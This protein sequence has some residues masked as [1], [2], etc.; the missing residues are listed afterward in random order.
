[1]ARL[2]STF[3]R[4][5]GSGGLNIFSVRSI[6]NQDVLKVF[7]IEARLIGFLIGWSLGL[8]VEEKPRAHGGTRRRVS[9][10]CFPPKWGC[11]NTFL[12]SVG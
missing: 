11:V 3:R 10:W 4:E 5:E 1:M 12:L 9:K 6:N 7:D 2:T 8:V